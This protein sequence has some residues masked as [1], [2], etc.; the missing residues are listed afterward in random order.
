MICTKCGVLWPYRASATGCL[1]CG[2]KLRLTA[3]DLLGDSPARIVSEIRAP[4]VEFAKVLD[5]GIREGKHV[6]AEVGTG[7]GKSF[8]LLI[9]AILSG[10]KTVVSTATTLLQ[11]QYIEKDLPFLEEKLAP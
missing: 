11:S 10:K 7:T 4:Q 3:D 2:G 1:T 5:R 6:T 9:P 8:A